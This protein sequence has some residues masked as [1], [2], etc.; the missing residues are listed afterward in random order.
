[1]LRIEASAEAMGCRYSVALYGPDRQRLELAVEA[2]FEEVNRLDLLLSN[3]QDSSE[4]SL[5]N[6]M[7]AQRPVRVDPELFRLLATCE[8]YSA[9]SEGAFDLT[10]GPLMRVW[11]FYRGTGA[12]PAPAELTRAMQT[13]GY[14]NVF[15]DGAAH[16]VSFAKAGVELDPGGIGKGYAIDCMAAVLRNHGIESGFLT[17]AGSSMYALGTPPAQDGWHVEIPD[18]RTANAIAAEVVL[19]NQSLS[20]SG[21][22][23]KFF[24]ADGRT[25]SHIMDPRTGYPAQGMLS[26]SVI[27]S[28]AT[29]SEAW[30][31]PMFINGREWADK[32]RPAGIR[33]FVCEDQPGACTWLQ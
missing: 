26:V 8:H 29:E 23:E 22:A 9:L 30:T 18:P 3:Y 21:T 5:V 14:R 13:V 32:H 17:A 28:S 15:L 10:V 27:A 24:V 6:R 31:K 7:A 25:Y 2:V 12:L 19:Q 11:G 1:M 16:T 4:L 20:T 33:A